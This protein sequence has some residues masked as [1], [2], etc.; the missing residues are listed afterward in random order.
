MCQIKAEQF[1]RLAAECERQAELAS[2]EPYFRT[3]QSRLAKS[4]HALA[5]TEDW[6]D[7]LMPD[8]AEVT[9]AILR[10]HAA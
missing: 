4:Y 2:T 3:V 5:E 1:R 7:G 8:S 9:G 6:L 10:P